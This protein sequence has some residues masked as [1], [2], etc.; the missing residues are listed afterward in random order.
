MERACYI[1]AVVRTTMLL[2]VFAIACSKPAP[3]EARPPPPDDRPTPNPGPTHDGDRAAPPVAAAPCTTGKGNTYQA[4]AGPTPGAPGTGPA[5]PHTARTAPR[6]SRRVRRGRSGRPPGSAAQST[7][8]PQQG[9]CS[10]KHR[11]ASC[12]SS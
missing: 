8:S 5:R 11:Q 7:Q 1:I 3:N 2:A 9:T 6:G 12:T 10:V 4:G